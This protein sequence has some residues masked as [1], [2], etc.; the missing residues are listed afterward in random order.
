ML[1]DEIGFG[2]PELLRG[3]VTG[4]NAARMDSAMFGRFDIMPHIPDEKSFMRIQTILAQDFVNFGPFIQDLDV[5]PLEIMVEPN[6]LGLGGIMVPMHCAQEEEPE[7]AAAAV[8]Q[9]FPSV[10]KFADG[11][12]DGAEMSM[13]PFFELR[14]GNI[15]G[16]PI[17]KLF[18][19]EAEFGSKGFQ[20]DFLEAGPAEDVVGGFPNSGQIIHQ[21]AGPI[22]NDVSNHGLEFTR[23]CCLGN[24]RNFNWIVHAIHILDNGNILVAGGF[25]RINEISRPYL[26]RL[27]PDGALDLTFNP[28][29]EDAAGLPRNG[30]IES[31]A[32]QEDA[33]I[34]V[35]GYFGGWTERPGLSRFH[36][37]GA[38]DQAFEPEM[39]MRMAMRS[40]VVAVALQPDQKILAGGQDIAVNGK[41]RANII[42]LHPDGSRDA[43]FDPGSGAGHT[44]S[45]IVVQEDGKIL[46]GG[47]FTQFNGIPRS[48]IVR[49]SAMGQ[50]IRRLIQ[51]RLAG[52]SSTG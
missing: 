26:A 7:F 35:G 14:H 34:V 8:I 31:I 46:L 36:P 19:R 39:E 40:Q 20:S 42:R 3:I 32:V 5:R 43:S 21:G 51:V 37:N 13:E 10:R 48:R 17:I 44:V 25:Q 38:W 16:E 45:A 30:F 23:S 6:H 1:D 47:W 15:W 50:S 11:I 12:L 52:L 49:L 9:K 2:R 24:E 4:E 29:P 41:L 28:G 18:E 22:K 27:F 33:K